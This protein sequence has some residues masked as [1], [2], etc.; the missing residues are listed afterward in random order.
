MDMTSLEDLAY[1]HLTR[2]PNDHSEAT[3]SKMKRRYG[4]PETRKALNTMADTLRMTGAFIGH[5]S[6]ANQFPI[7]Y[8]HTG[9]DDSHHRTNRKGDTALRRKTP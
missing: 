6:K 2:H 3:V 9:N 8:S 1:K 7:P 4:I 5:I